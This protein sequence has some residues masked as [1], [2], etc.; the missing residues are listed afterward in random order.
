MG[1]LEASRYSVELK[2]KPGSCLLPGEG[3]NHG[4]FYR[5]ALLQTGKQAQVGWRQGHHGP[6]FKKH[7]APMSPC[8]GNWRTNGLPSSGVQVSVRKTEGSS[9]GERGCA[10]PEG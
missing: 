6:R 1:S 2:I 5:P 7:P 9:P 3:T 4:H 10:G 8:E